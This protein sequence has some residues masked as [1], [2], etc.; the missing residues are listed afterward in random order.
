M[1]AHEQIR[2]IGRLGEVPVDSRYRRVDGN[3]KFV[4]I[5]VLKLIH[6]FDDTIRGAIGKPIG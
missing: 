6:I 2:I 4:A 5:L 1:Q 3:D